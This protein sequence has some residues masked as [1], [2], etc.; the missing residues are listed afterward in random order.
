ML[1]G[2]V[3]YSTYMRSFHYKILNNV[4]FLNKKLHT[5]GIKLSPLCSFCNL[6]NETPLHIFYECDSV[7]CLW[8]DLDFFFQKNLILTTLTPQAAIFRILQSP[9]S[10]SIFKNNKVFI[11][12]ILLMLKLYVFKS[13]E[14]KFIN[15]NNLI[16]EI[17]KVKRTEK[18]VAL[19][20]SIRN[21]CFYKEMAH[22]K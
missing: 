16:A 7:K 19:S 22:N 21:I 9:S 5:F 17:R 8:S 15:L 6:Y 11:K 12:H 20:M 2:I 13:R 3:T 18:E 14:K 10:E 4:L 1:P